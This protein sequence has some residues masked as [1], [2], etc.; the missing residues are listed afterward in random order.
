MIKLVIAE[1][2]WSEEHSHS[3]HMHAACSPQTY[4]LP[5]SPGQLVGGNNVDR[6]LSTPSPLIHPQSSLYQTHHIP[7]LTLPTVSH[8][9]VQHCTPGV[10]TVLFYNG[11]NPNL[12][13]CAGDDAACRLA[14]TSDRTRIQ[15]Q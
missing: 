4:K 2:R 8:I 9:L 14:T 15:R 6:G 11:N 7:H 1:V 10:D 13:C 5:D 3:V 12:A